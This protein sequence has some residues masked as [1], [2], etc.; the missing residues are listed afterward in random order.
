MQV[1]VISLDGSGEN[2]L[3]RM[4]KKYSIKRSLTVNT[5]FAD[6]KDMSIPQFIIKGSNGVAKDRELAK[7]LLTE[8]VRKELSK[9]IDDLFQDVD[10]IYLIAN[11]G[12]G[13]WSGI[14]PIVSNLIKSNF[15]NKVICS[16]VGMPSH[17][18]SSKELRN[19][20]KCI[21]ELVKNKNHSYKVFKS[22][23][24]FDKTDEIVC[25]TLMYPFL[26]R[27]SIT[28]NLDES[29]LKTIYN[30]VGL[31]TPT[32]LNSKGEKINDIFIESDMVETTGIFADN[33]KIPPIDK[34]FGLVFK[35][36][37]KTELP[38]GVFKLESGQRLNME[39]LKNVRTTIDKK[40]KEEESKIEIKKVIEESIKMAD[41]LD[42]WKDREFMEVL[43]N[44]D[45]SIREISLVTGMKKN[46]IEKFLFL[47]QK[48]EEYGLKSLSGK[49]PEGVWQ[50]VERNE[51]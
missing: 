19:G 43:G 36:D 11:G 32:M 7:K 18:S 21:I 41:E 40:E 30:D 50:G 22:E 44:I 2:I 4:K 27:E 46:R 38:T 47:K 49:C 23:E 5:N 8:E 1:G 31:I 12:G 26:P 35:G 51:K 42:F 9:R 37:Y 16:V 17:T 28:E 6:M 29:E 39:H 15:P 10:F 45:L 24:P 13:S 14:L 20:A 3:R 33:M 25:K 48:L 34:I